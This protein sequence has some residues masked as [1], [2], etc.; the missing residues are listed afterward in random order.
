MSDSATTQSSPQPINQDT[1]AARTSSNEPARATDGRFEP[2]Q[3]RYPN[4]YHVAWMRG[5]T[6][7]EVGQLSSQMYDVLQNQSQGQPSQQPQQR[8]ESQEPTNDE[9]LTDTAGASRK[10]GEHLRRT[11][12]EPVINQYATALGQQARAIVEMRDPDAFKRW[13]PEIDTY[14]ARYMPQPAQRNVESIAAVVDLVRGKHVNELIAEREREV[15]SRAQQSNS[16]RADGAAASGAGAGSANRV[17]FTNVGLPDNYRR[18]LERYRI[19]PDTLDEFLTSTECRVR[20]ITLQ[21][22]REEWLAKAKAGDVITEAPLR[23]G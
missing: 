11:Q 23:I 8:V 9:W 12:F 22:A 7:D 14:I 1:G 17:D 4:D 16:M 10:F 21:Q 3:W 18:T 19:T 5:K 6:A 20:G 13:G 15:L 2:N